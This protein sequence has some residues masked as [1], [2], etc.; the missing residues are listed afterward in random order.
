[1][2]ATQTT[3]H[4]TA[5]FPL[6]FDLV[7]ERGTEMVEKI[8]FAPRLD[9][10]TKTLVWLIQRDNA[11][12]FALQITDDLSKS[13]LRLS[14]PGALTIELHTALSRQLKPYAY[15]H[16]LMMKDN[17]TGETETL[18]VGALMVE[19]HS[20]MWTDDG[21]TVPSE[22]PN[23]G[24][25]NGNGVPDNLDFAWDG[26]LNLDP[27]IKQ[28]IDATTALELANNTLRTTIAFM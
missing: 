17:A 22:L 5:N 20:R 10:S 18:L 15:R 24:D 11:P 28:L 3:F 16:A 26:F 19:Q 13:G 8:E 1:M 12:V 6:F 21:Q 7:L 27:K 14:G 9:F 23:I 2:I 4:H 25:Q